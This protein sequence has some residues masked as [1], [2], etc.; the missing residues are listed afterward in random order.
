MKTDV[1]APLL[2]IITSTL[3]C[4]IELNATAR[5]IR[6]QTYTNIQWIIADG[7]SSSATLDV[8]RENCDIVDHSFSERDSGIYEAWNRACVS[9]RGDWVYFLGA[10]DVFVG[11]NVLLNLFTS[12]ASIHLHS[13]CKLFYGN[14]RLVTQNGNVRNTFK[15]INLKKWEFGRPAL[16]AHQGVFQHASLFHPTSTFDQSLRVAGDSKFLLGVLAFNPITYINQDVC[17][18]DDSGASNA[19][20]NGFRIQKEIDFVCKALDINVPFYVSWRAWLFRF[21]TYFTHFFLPFGLIRLIK[22]IRHMVRSSLE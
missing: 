15:E 14:V 2:T 11:P 7:G 4:P 18:M 19:W 22:A 8:I 1:Q 3:D 13:S 9:I 5:S 17:L 6:S 20:R 12:L 21:L 10:G 16:P